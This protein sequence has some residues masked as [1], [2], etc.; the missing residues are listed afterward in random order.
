MGGNPVDCL[1]RDGCQVVG[2]DNF[3]TDDN[4]STCQIQ[5]PFDSPLACRCL[6]FVCIV[7]D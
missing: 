7:K 4:N 6:N 5:R 1:L 2:Y 3:S